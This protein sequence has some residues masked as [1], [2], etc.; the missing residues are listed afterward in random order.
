MEL[1]SLLSITPIYVAVLGLVFIV[2]TVRVGI[3]RVKTKINIGTGDDPEMIRRTRGQ[4]NFIETVPMAL[5]L[6]IMMEILGA[7]DTWLHVLG[8]VLVV[9]RISHYIGLT[10]LGPIVF[11]ASGML[12]TMG[13]ILVS[14]VW[15]L[16]DVI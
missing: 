16:I 15:I 3:Y 14:S 13:T 9:A 2:F 5:F 4:A 10:E 6:L 1:P 8:M 7:S 12:G 11:R